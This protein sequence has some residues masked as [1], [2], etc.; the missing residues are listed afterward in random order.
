MRNCRCFLLHLFLSSLLQFL[1]SLSL[2]LF[3]FSYDNV[4]AIRC[5]WQMSKS[6]LCFFSLSTNLLCFPS[7]VWIAPFSLS[8][9]PGTQLHSGGRRIRINVQSELSGSLGRERVAD[10]ALIL[11]PGHPPFQSITWLI[12]LSNQFLFC[13]F[14]KLF[15]IFYPLHAWSQASDLYIFLKN[16]LE[17]QLQGRL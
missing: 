1:L 16:R 10:R 4:F 7:K 15:C 8:V 6:C 12:L 5:K 3:L 13:C 17:V 14:T 9:W 11:Q 2:S